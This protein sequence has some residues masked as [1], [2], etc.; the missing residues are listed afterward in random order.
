MFG[1]IEDMIR[2][3]L[4][5]IILYLVGRYVL[6]R[7]WTRIRNVWLHGAIYAVG[8]CFLLVRDELVALNLEELFLAISIGLISGMIWVYLIYRNENELVSMKFSFK[9]TRIPQIVFWV[10]VY[11]YLHLKGLRA[12]AIMLLAITS[13]AIVGLC[14]TLVLERILKKELHMRN[15][16]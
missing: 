11:I 3:I 15:T 10:L 6:P 2:L 14:G 8:V 16:K 9:K 5:V 1:R 12:E 7:D 4:T 13:Q